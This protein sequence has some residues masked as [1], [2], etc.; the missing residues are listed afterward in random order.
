MRGS[1]ADPL[2]HRRRVLSDPA[3][4]HDLVARF[5][6]VKHLVDRT[7]AFALRHEDQKVDTNTTQKQR[8]KGPDWPAFLRGGL[9]HAER[10]AIRAGERIISVLAQPLDIEGKEVFVQASIG[11]AFAGL[12]IQISRKVMSARLALLPGALFLTIPFAR[13]LDGTHHWF[14]GLAVVAAIAVLIEKRT[15]ARISAAG[16][17]C[18]LALCFTQMRGLLSALGIGVFLLWEARRNLQGWRDKLRN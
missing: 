10:E 5:Q 13:F 11:L 18:G 7:L 6:V 16:A 2:A 4:E 1:D 12:S 3:A 17:L 15:P 14:S 8:D 9:S